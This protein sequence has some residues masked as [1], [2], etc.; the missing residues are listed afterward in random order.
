MIT[1]SYVIG[2]YAKEKE[3]RD[4][5]G[6]AETMEIK[7]SRK[8][9]KIWEK[10]HPILN[11]F[12]DIYYDIN[13]K[14]NIPEDKYREIKWFIQ[15]GKRGYSDRDVW[16]FYDYL[17]KVIVGGL[18]DLKKQVHGSPSGFC[19]VHGIDLEGESPETKK[20]KRTIDKMLWTFEAI[21]KIENHE[22]N[23]VYNEKDREELKKFVRRYNRN[24]EDKLFKDVELPKM[25][26]MTK[27]EMKKYNE[28]WDLFKKYFMDL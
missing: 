18:K 11:F 21:E 2:F 19:N 23:P 6:S 9:T 26:L 22:W 8:R 24:T 5:W 7:E 17:T 12:Q 15:R 10:K 27:R 3:H 28:G 16:G 4:T 13:R 1:T 20:W 25:H 14:K